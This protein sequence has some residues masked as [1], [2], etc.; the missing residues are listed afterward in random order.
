M[1]KEAIWLRG[2][3]NQIRPNMGLQTVI[4]FGDNQGA[5]ALAKN[6]LH[7]SRVKHIDIQYHWVRAQIADENVDLKYVST[8]KQVANKLT[9]ALCRDKFERFRELIGLEP[10]P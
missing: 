7:H 3:L 4:I 10:H 8:D 2:L 9:K 6:P 1:A 5:I